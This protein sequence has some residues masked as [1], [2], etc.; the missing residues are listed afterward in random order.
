MQ[1]RSDGGK[2]GS[3]QVGK[4]KGGQKAPPGNFAP[5]LEIEMV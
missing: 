1:Y 5:I 4:K 2:K 3:G